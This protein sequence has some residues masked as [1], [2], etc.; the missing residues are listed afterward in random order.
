MRK[1]ISKLSAFT[2]FELMLVMILI[3]IIVTILGS[4]LYNVNGFHKRLKDR[5]DTVGSFKEFKYAIN[6]DFNRM[7]YYEITEQ[8]LIF[9]NGVDS[10]FYSFGENIVRQQSVRVDSIQVEGTL[11]FNDSITSIRLLLGERTT[12]IRLPSASSGVLSYK[13]TSSETTDV[14]GTKEEITE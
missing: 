8:K 13:S 12:Q 2:L 7:K 5:V 1:R 9:T 10:V 4:A 14:S 3:S 6:R 11:F